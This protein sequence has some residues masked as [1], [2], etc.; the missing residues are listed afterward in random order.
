MPTPNFNLKIISLILLPISLLT[1]STSAWFYFKN[2]TSQSIATNITTNSN[3]SSVAILSSTQSQIPNS[4]SAISSTISSDSS[5][6]SS[7]IDQVMSSISSVSEQVNLNFRQLTGQDFQ[8]IFESINYPKTQLTKEQSVITDNLVV[9]NHIRSL[10]QK[11]GYKKRPSAF[12]NNLVFVDGQ[13][14][15]LEAKDAWNNLRNQAKNE[16]FNLVITSGFRSSVEQRSMFVASMAPEYPTQDLLS[17]KIDPD[18][19]TIMN[20][21]SP[22]GYSRHHTG[23]TIDIAC[24]G[25]STSFKLT[26]CYR[27]ASA[28]NFAKVRQFGWIPS[29]PVG[30]NNQGPN[31]EEWEF[32]WVGDL[33]K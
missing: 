23:Y 26:S 2:S 24:L 20:I 12:D 22:P 15:Q 18:L 6:S 19:N 32:V 28:N 21:V 31:P 13:R 1:I 14:L 25:E 16:G 9:D 33:A 5:Q 7:I 8:A 17:G 11:R 27:W 29:Y 3:S 30:V 4:S 10:A